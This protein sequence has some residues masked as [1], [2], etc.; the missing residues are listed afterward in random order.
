MDP[1][2]NVTAQDQQDLVDEVLINLKARPNQ[3]TSGLVKNIGIMLSAYELCYKVPELN[4]CYDELKKLSHNIEPSDLNDVLFD[5]LLSEQ[6]EARQNF[7]A[8][9]SSEPE[10]QKNHLKNNFKLDY[11]LNLCKNQIKS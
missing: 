10:N 2:S 11:F 7:T 4:E 1:F 5:L 8:L 6:S 3:K 9:L